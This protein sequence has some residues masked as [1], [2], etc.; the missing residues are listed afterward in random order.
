MPLG[1]DDV[2]PADEF[3]ARPQAVG[4]RLVAVGFHFRRLAGAA[5]F[6][7]KRVAALA[8][9]VEPCLGR[10]LDI[11]PAASHVRGDR[12]VTDALAAVVGV[13]V[14]RHRDDRRLA[15]V[16]FGVQYLV[17]HTVLALQHVAQ[18]LALFDA[19]RAHQHRAAGVAVELDFFDYRVPLFRFGAVNAIVVISTD[20]I[21]VRPEW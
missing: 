7:C 21:A 1:A 4:D 3:H 20:A 12:D 11:G 6:E 16:I 17:L 8:D 18:P 19:G 9:D 10:Q 13:R 5:L 2:Q 14:P 15:L